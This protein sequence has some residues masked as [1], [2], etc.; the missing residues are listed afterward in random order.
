MK[1]KDVS[2]KYNISADTLR[3]W[4]RVG[5]IPP[6]TRDSSGNRAYD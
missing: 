6:V 2:K 5:A 1:I 3:Y 4:E